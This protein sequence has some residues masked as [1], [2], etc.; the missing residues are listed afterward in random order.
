MSK[1][2]KQW[3]IAAAV[4][5]VLVVA[6]LLGSSGL[7]TGALK[8]GAVNVNRLTER[9]CRQIQIAMDSGSLTEKFGARTGEIYEACR[10]RFPQAMQP[11]GTP[12]SQHLCRAAIAASNEGQLTRGVW[13]YNLQRCMSD[14]PFLF[15]QLTTTAQCNALENWDAR[16]LITGTFPNFRGALTTCRAERIRLEEMCRSLTAAIKR[17]GW[18]GELSKDFEECTSKLPLFFSRAS[19]ISGLTTDLDVLNENA[20]SPLEDVEGQWYASAANTAYTL[21]WIIGD[22]FGGG[23]SLTRQEY[24]VLV[25]NILGL[26][27][28]DAAAL[29]AV[30]EDRAQ[31]ADWAKEAVQCALANNVMLKFANSFRPHSSVKVYDAEAAVALIKQYI[32]VND[33]DVLEIAAERL[34]VD[35]QTLV[36]ALNSGQNIVDG[37]AVP[38]L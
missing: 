19:I 36:D 27:N 9:Q 7:F 17:D 3:Y 4:V 26:S 32:Q 34:G 20:R 16:G 24:A 22:R 37:Q 5:A 25:S 10:A 14:Y 29:D 31:I 12:I 2:N 6:G 1:T 33:V 13:S 38:V 28:C 23:A 8:G 35:R 18:T 11:T 21:G 30:N 15:S